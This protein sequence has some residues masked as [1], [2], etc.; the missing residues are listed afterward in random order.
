MSDNRLLPEDLT[1]IPR[2]G[3]LEVYDFLET[4]SRGLEEAAVA[5]RRA[6]YGWN[7][8]RRARR[9]SLLA[10]F[11]LQFTDLFAVLLLVASGITF[12]VYLLGG[13]PGDRNLSLAILGV[14]IL[15]ALVGFVQEFRAERATEVL[16][17]LVPV[18]AKAYRGGREVELDAAEL[19]PGDVLVLEEGD[20]IPADARLVQAFE[21][22]TN[23]TNLTGE[24]DPQ[25]KT[26]AAVF[27]EGLSWI[28]YPNLIF[29]GTSVAAGSG[30]AVVFATGE[31][32]Q[33]GKIFQLTAGVPDVPSPLQK[34][35][36]NM[37]RL[38]ARAALVIGVTFFGLGKLLGL[39]WIE[40][41]LF[42]LGVMVAMVPE[43]LPATLSV[44]LA[45]GVQRMARRNAL[46]KRLSAVEAL[47][48]ANVICTD[49]TGTLT[50]GEMTV[51]E[52]WRPGER[53]LVAGAGYEPAGE[54]RAA[55]DG[56][57]G[58]EGAPLGPAERQK[59]D[60]F[61][62]AAAFCNTARLLPP[63][64]ENPAWSVLGDP[65]EGAL[66]VLAKKAGFAWEE[67]LREE[68]RVYL[69]PF[70]SRRKRMSS[71][72]R[73]NGRVAAYVKGAPR[74]VVALCTGVLKDG[75]VYP[76]GE[77]ERSEVLRQN[78][79]MSR[80][81]LRVLAFAYREL[82]PE[83]GGYR[84]EEVER[85]LVFLGL[86]GMQDP[87]R[88]EV[89]AAVRSAKG[90][91][92]RLIMITGDYGLTAEAIASRISITGGARARILTGAELAGM[93]ADELRG[94]LAREEP[95]VFAR[96]TP[97]HK[98][99]VVAALQE[100]G[101]IV[102]VTG[103]GVNDGPAL[104]R[105]D[106][107]IAMGRTGTDVAREAA[108]MILLDDSFASIVQAIE[109]GRA[110]YANIRKFIL[111]LFSHN[112]G[113]LLPFLF[114]TVAGVHLIPLTALQI[115]AIDLGSDVL[116]AL[117]LGIERPEPGL[118]QQPP[119]SRESRLFDRA[120]VKRILFLGGI[121]GAWVT[122]G[123]LFVLL[124]GGW[125]WGTP[126]PAGDPLYRQAITMS[127]AAVVVSQVFNAFA[128]RTESSSVFRVGIFSNRFLL[129]GEAVG[130]A[131]MAAISYVPFFQ[132]LFNTAP[133][134]LVDWALLFV[135]GATILAAE[136][137]RKFAVR[138]GREQR[139]GGGC[140]S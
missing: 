36:R 6:R 86:A 44:S 34:Q 28:E 50:K 97:E 78:D 137:L 26:A 123:F 131:I 27:E 45:V 21:L 53:V 58:E 71:L 3:P 126:L 83:P 68:P 72:H 73:R 75:A 17:K 109:Q 63:G 64:E 33:F 46:I 19:V 94:L 15:N 18:K 107:G 42:A 20:K 133:L 112:M 30:I 41:F 38:V 43:G 129:V 29:M 1:E 62:R 115:L 9:R 40:G 138:R 116:P 10:R 8:V 52:I 104:K 105:A 54:L 101:R 61:L 95:L 130:L 113:E 76:L 49:K 55:R 35:V 139:A 111:Y 102:A 14:V 80:E 92:I 48:S 25:P 31:R 110:V 87:P 51:R 93:D 4:S 7:R 108:V 2:L 136:E 82:P 60:F 5:D 57:A 47:G 67:K 88:P 120:L 106:I 69:L 140:G 24:A 12:T 127:Q 32:T 91:G 118:M 119:R 39:G 125:R 84:A 128:V 70:D 134:R 89:A 122:A 99:R 117:A 121:Q 96:V 59:W 98:M 66:L 65:T 56:A 100:L 74:E 132:R 103:D 77:E 16:N 22:S 90:A 37:A 85:E 23:N 13:N 114:A 79:R 135:F 81:G 11:L 124:D